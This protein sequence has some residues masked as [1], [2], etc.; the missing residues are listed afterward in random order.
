MANEVNKMA[1]KNIALIAHKKCGTTWLWQMFDKLDGCEVVHSKNLPNIWPSKPVFLY[2][3]HAIYNHRDDLEYIRKRCDKALMIFRDPQEAAKSLWR[4]ETE[5][6]KRHEAKIVSG[7]FPVKTSLNKPNLT[8][9]RYS[10]FNYNWSL[11]KV[12]KYFTNY[13]SVG[14]DFYLEN[15]RTTVEQIINFWGVDLELP[16]KLPPKTNVSYEPRSR[17]LYWII[18]KAFYEMTGLPSAYIRK[19]FADSKMRKSPLWWLYRL[20][21]RY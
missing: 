1:G 19:D 8:D 15:Q 17:L 10:Y 14:Y 2:W 5:G 18:N 20:N 3:P 6:L 11:K 21:Q 4:D 16:D 9:I 13:F 7:W 12:Q